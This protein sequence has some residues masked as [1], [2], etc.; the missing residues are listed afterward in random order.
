MK[1]EN[2]RM[3]AKKI[4]NCLEKMHRQLFSQVLSELNKVKVHMGQYNLLYFLDDEG[5]CPMTRAA[6]GLYVTTSAVTAMTDGLVKKGMV[7]RKRGTRDRR[8]VEISITDKGEKI[9]NKIR[10]QVEGFYIPIL[11]SLGKKDSRELVKLHMEMYRIMGRAK[12]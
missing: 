11:D 5:V 2:V 12:K 9:V 6:R 4:Q 1:D 8:I 3:Q 10:R 7:K